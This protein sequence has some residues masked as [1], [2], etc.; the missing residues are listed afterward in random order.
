MTKVVIKAWRWK[1]HNINPIQN[2]PFRFFSRMGWGQKDPLH[3]ICYTCSIILK[4]GTV[5]L[6]LREI[7]NI[8]NIYITWHNP[9]AEIGFFRQKLANFAIW[10]ITSKNSI[11]INFYFFLI[12]SWKVLEIWII[13]NK[14]YGVMISVHDVT[15]KILSCNSNYVVKVFMWPNLL[16]LA[17]LWE[18]VS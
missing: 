9:S 7:K 3:E 15:N 8:K 10:R 11:L 1:L 5:M 18:K 2:G 14:I 16:T 13:S 17:L 12:E 6:Y 4:L